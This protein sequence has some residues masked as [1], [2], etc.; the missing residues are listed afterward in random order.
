MS[1]LLT[2]RTL[3]SIQGRRT[4]ITKENA[5]LHPLQRPLRRK[6]KISVQRER[7]NGGLVPKRPVKV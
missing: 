6:K 5:S 1:F 3:E 2:V 4:P 7:K